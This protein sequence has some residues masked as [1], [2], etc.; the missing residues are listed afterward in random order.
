MRG[1]EREYWREAGSMV[2]SGRGCGEAL[3][4]GEGAKMVGGIARDRRRGKGRLRANGG[5]ALEPF[6][7]GHRRCAAM[8]LVALSSLQS[9]STLQRVHVFPAIETGAPRPLTATTRKLHQTKC[10]ET[11]SVWGSQL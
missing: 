6:K 5:D 3:T 9:R 1:V 11:V 7:Q 10:Q 2:D 8:L 4:R